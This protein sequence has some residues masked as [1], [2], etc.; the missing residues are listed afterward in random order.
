MSRWR[1]TDLFPSVTGRVTYVAPDIDTVYMDEITF[2]YTQLQT[3]RSAVHS[4][5]LA[6]CLGQVEH[7][8]VPTTATV[9]M[10]RGVV[11]SSICKHSP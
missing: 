8:L 3:E 9:S 4:L 5:N 2:Q 7:L 1:R 11:Y 10:L 6:S